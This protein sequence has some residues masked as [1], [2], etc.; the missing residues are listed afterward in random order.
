MNRML[1]LGCVF[2]VASV[3]ACASAN[4]RRERDT[5]PENYLNQCA[6]KREPGNDWR[7]LR[8]REKQM[9][10]RVYLPPPPDGVFPDPAAVHEAVRSGILA[11]EGVVKPGVPSFEFVDTPG[12]AQIPIQWNASNDGGWFIAHLV[13]RIR[14]DRFGVENMLLTLLVVGAGTSLAATLYHATRVAPALGLR[15][16]PVPVEVVERHLANLR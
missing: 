7:L 10:L 8:W 11:W 13:Y 9:P 2:L 6:F 1:R 16:D 15:H 5:T 14:N 12:G 3:L 4:E